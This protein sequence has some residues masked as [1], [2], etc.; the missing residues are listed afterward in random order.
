MF[1]WNPAYPLLQA[2]RI[3]LGAQPSKGGEGA[4]SVLANDLGY[5]GDHL[6]HASI[7]ALVFLCLGYAVFMSRRHKYADLV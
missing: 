3:V 1:A 6:L 5:L 4:P 7:W 2:H